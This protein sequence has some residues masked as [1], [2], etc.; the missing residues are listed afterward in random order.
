MLQA[1]L[2]SVPCHHEV[3]GH[4]A[5]GGGDV[6]LVEEVFYELQEIIDRFLLYVTSPGNFFICHAYSVI[7]AV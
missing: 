3:I 4:L 5:L 1:V 6:M 2:Y 7:Y